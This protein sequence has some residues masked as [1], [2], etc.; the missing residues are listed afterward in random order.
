MILKGIKSSGLKAYNREIDFGALSLIVGPTG[1]GKTSLLDAIQILQRGEHASGEKKLVRP[2]DLLSEFGCNGDAIEIEGEYETVKAIRKIEWKG[3]GEKTKPNHTL[4]TSLGP[5]KIKKQQERLDAKLGT[6]GLH[7][8]IKQFI[9]SNE[10]EKRDL[11]LSM[12]ASA[13]PMD[14]GE[15]QRRI[16]EVPD[17]VNSEATHPLTWLDEI[18][19]SVTEILSAK[20]ARKKELD[21]S[22]RESAAGSAIGSPEIVRQNDEALTALKAE[23]EDIA[24]QLGG[25]EEADRTRTQITADLAAKESEIEKAEARIATLDAD[26]AGLAVAKKEKDR[27]TGALVNRKDERDKAQREIE[28]VKTDMGTCREEM[29]AAAAVRKTTEERLDQIKS[30]TC[31]LCESDKVPASLID[32]LQATLDRTALEFEKA[33]AHT[34][35][36]NGKLDSLAREK[37][38]AQAGV[39][40]AEKDLDAAKDTLRDYENKIKTLSETRDSLSPL[41]ARLVELRE[42]LAESAAPVSPEVLTALKEGNEQQVGVA[43]AALKE[44]QEALAAEKAKAKS[45]VESKRLE[46][47]IET[48]TTLK[49]EVDAIRIEAVTKMI[50]PLSVS[51]QRFLGPLG[52]FTVKLEDEK[53]RVCFRPGI[54]RDG[55]FREI[56]R[57]S[58]GESIAAHFGLIVGLA[59]FSKAE[60]F[61]APMVDDLQ[62]LDGSMRETFLRLVL[63]LIEDAEIDQCFV[64]W[65]A[66]PD[67]LPGWLQEHEAVK[68]INLWGPRGV[69]AEAVEV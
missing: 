5:G 48:L 61:N 31:P 23:A 69:V 41:N 67:E 39:D 4:W 66:T 68:V 40:T 38:N 52:Q 19:E 58:G 44:A 36:L 29:A 18:R 14:L 30:G 28:T 12:L 26:S 43:S 34:E 46:A 59:A 27:A 62:L 3:E 1:A 25:I 49:T 6:G 2:V 13:C 65:N 8:S 50:D 55:V 42:R 21:A 20:N 63:D 53:G 15:V 51:L 64:T 16:G 33:E 47:E 32:D 24:R 7:Y 22:A 9:R 54:E 60:G 10:R 17:G 37:V 45:I 56:A 35:A 57:L 11:L